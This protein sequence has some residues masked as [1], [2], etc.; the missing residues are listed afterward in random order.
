[1]DKDILSQVIE[2]EKEIQ[3]CLDREK[4]K[5]RE[6]IERVRKEC[7]AEYVREEQLIRESLDRSIAENASEAEKAAAGIVSRAETEAMRLGRVSDGT[8]S[9]IVGNHIR[10]ILPE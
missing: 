2:A 6:W 4:V 3:L 9:K 7:E 1:M 10:C 5:T 8:L